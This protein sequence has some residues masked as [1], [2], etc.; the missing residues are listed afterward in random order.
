MAN[1]AGNGGQ[2]I[3]VVIMTVALAA[4]AWEALALAW[5][6]SRDRL[7]LQNGV[8]AGTTT[9]AA[10]LA[11]GLNTVA[12]TNQALLALGIGALLGNGQFAQWAVQL[13]RMQD[14]VIRRTPDLARQAART[15]AIGLGAHW[16]AFPGEGQR[17]PGL[18]VRRMY[19]LPWFFGRRFPLWLAD[20]LRPVG[21][22][23]WGDRVL[24][25]QGWRLARRGA[26]VLPLRAGAGAAA[27]RPGGGGR[28]SWPLLAADYDSRLI[29]GPGQG[30]TE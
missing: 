26:V 17:W 14:E 6:M 12:V 20:D 2:A 4:V 3:L 13:Q 19:F 16:A 23:R 28:S 8:D 24:Y 25:L 27:A 10:I 15:T 18:M 21:E 1:R 29:P 30:A 5:S 11:D 22:R 9:G 7:T